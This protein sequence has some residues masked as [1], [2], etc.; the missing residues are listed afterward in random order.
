MKKAARLTACIA[1][2]L[3]GSASPAASSA[4]ALH[5]GSHDMDFAIG[6]WRTETTSYKD[7]FN[8]PSKVAHMSGTK[9]ARTIWHGKGLIE[10]IEADG[11]AGHWEGATVFLY[12]PASHQ[13][14]QSYADGDTGRFDGTTEIGEYRNG[15]LEF[16]WQSVVD[17]RAVLER[18][19]WTDIMPNSHTYRIQ[20]SNDGGRTWHTAFEAHLT[21]IP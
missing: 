14:S 18:G 17:N 11:P 2:I 16:Y 1:L 21:R 8:D 6:K 4:R 12:D 19:I 10:E 20:R 13:W 15:N 9:T 5:D 7:P 3:A